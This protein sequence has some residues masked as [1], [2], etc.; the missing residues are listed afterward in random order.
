MPEVP[1]DQ[2]LWARP[3]NNPLGGRNMDDDKENWYTGCCYIPRKGSWLWCFFEAGNINN[4]Y[5]TT[6]LDIENTKV[7]PE[8]QVGSNYQNKWTIFKSGEGRCIVVSDDPDDARVEI[9]GKKRQMT[10]APTGD[11]DSVYQI[12]ENQTTILFDERDGSE[13]ILIRTYKG[14]YLNIDIEYQSLLAYFDKDIVI[15]AGRDI[16]V[17]A[18]RDIRVDSGGSSFL[19]AT[20]NIDAKSGLDMSLTSGAMM[21]VKS[22]ADMNI[23]STSSS[24]NISAMLNVNIQATVNVSVTAGAALSLS[25][26]L[27]T[28]IQSLA[29]V[30][31]LAAAAFSLSGVNGSM[32]SSGDGGISIA[33]TASFSVQAATTISFDGGV[34]T[35]EQCGLSIPPVPVPPTPPEPASPA[36]EAEEANPDEPYGD[37]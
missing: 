35:N 36:E 19:N 8:N 6:G 15:Q 22:E 21:Q 12:D 29:T 4:P 14:D 33:S 5:Y 3:A 24:V 20:Y 26:T 9:T 37:R 16:H 28:S 13:K 32:G 17:K 10:N 2:G 31:V 23:Q 27:A 30:S 34:S 25:S 18:G 11:L 7:L 1:D